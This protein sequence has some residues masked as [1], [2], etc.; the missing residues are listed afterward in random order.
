MIE[1]LISR[2]YDVK[3]SPKIPIVPVSVARSNPL[4]ISNRRSHHDIR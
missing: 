2:K 3:L 4:K 1:V